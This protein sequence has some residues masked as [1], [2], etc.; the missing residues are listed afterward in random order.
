MSEFRSTGETN[1]TEQIE[2]KLPVKDF[3]LMMQALSAYTHNA[4]YKDLF[5]RLLMVRL[6]SH[7]FPTPRDWQ[8]Q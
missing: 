2:V 6:V 7:E 8:D 1:E 5:D 4:E 3:D